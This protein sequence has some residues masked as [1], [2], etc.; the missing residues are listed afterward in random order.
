MGFRVSLILNPN[1]SAKTCVRLEK[2][3]LVTGDTAVVSQQVQATDRPCP[4]KQSPR[5]LGFGVEGLGFGVSGLGFR[6]RV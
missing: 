3:V 1:R 4:K 6:V 2:H 5:V